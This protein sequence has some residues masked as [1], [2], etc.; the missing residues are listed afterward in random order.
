MTDEKRKRKFRFS[1]RYFC[2][3]TFRASSSASFK[4]ML[5]VYKIPFE[6]LF[7]RRSTKIRST[8]RRKRIR[9]N[10]KARRRGRKTNTIRKNT[11]IKI[12]IKK[13]RKEKKNINTRRETRKERRRKKKLDH[14]H[15]KLRKPQ[16]TAESSMS[17]RDGLV[18]DLRP[19]LPVMLLKEKLLVA[20]ILGPQRRDLYRFWYRT[21]YLQCIGRIMRQRRW[22]RQVRLPTIV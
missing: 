10:T 22:D 8:E 17:M 3:L 21:H 11:E 19:G 4:I 9:R 13:E 7:C 16:K 15:Y 2:L 14:N 1:S 12:K 20:A 5:K 18:K 6:S